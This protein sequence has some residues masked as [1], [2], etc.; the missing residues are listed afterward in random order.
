MLFR[1]IVLGYRDH[2]FVME[3]GVPVYQ[4]LDGPQLEL[5]WYGSVGWQFSF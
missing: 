5:D 4:S 3:A 2:G 1:S